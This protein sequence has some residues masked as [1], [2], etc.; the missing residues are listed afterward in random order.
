M[1]ITSCEFCNSIPLSVSTINVRRLLR[2]GNDN[3]ANLLE[4]LLCGPRRRPL[5]LSDRGVT[6]PIEGDMRVLS[7]VPPAGFQDE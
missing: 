5:E 4:A 1:Q 3:V 7:Q 2:K 6:S